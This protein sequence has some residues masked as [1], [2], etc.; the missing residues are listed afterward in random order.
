MSKRSGGL[1]LDKGLNPRIWQLPLTDLSRAKIKTMRDFMIPLDETTSFVEMPD[2]N[3]YH[4]AVAPFMANEILGGYGFNKAPEIQVLQK[5]RSWT[6]N[7]PGLFT[8]YRLPERRK[9]MPALVFPKT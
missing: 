1:S 2:G 6:P 5:L 7:I 4:S 9:Y 3:S 8:Q